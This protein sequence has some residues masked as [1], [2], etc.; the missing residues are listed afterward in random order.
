MKRWVSFTLCGL[1]GLLLLLCGWLIPAHLR[2]V[3]EPVLQA[4]G[5]NSAS[6]VGRG[7]SLVH[8][9]PYGAGEIMLRAAQNAQLPDTNELS[10]AI[11]TE[12]KKYP[13]LKLWGA[14][15]PALRNYF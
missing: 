13:A 6:L 14:S 15:I 5:R 4:A 10:S 8:I 11:A 3:E 12:A 2:A 1:L 7:V 9:G